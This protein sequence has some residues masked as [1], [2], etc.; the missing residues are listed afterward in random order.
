MRYVKRFIKIPQRVVNNYTKNTFVP[1]KNVDPD[2]LLGVG[3]VLNF[4]IFFNIRENYKEDKLKNEIYNEIYK[5]Y[6]L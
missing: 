3:V 6:K 2:D 5:R 1:E 4:G